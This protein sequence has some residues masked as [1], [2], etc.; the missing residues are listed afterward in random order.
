MYSP[1]FQDFQVNTMW[2]LWVCLGF[3]IVSEIVVLCL[4]VGRKPPLNMICLGFFTLGESYLV[5]LV[6]SLTAESDGKFVVLMAALMTLAITISV[7]VYAMVTKTDFTAR[8][9]IT[10]VLLCGL[11]FMGILS[12]FFYSQFMYVL[13]CTLGVVL[14]GIYLIIDTQLIMGGKRLALSIDDYA[15]AAMLLYVDIIQMFLY[16]LS[17]MRN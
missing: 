6:C 7:T 16:L 1:A 9:G 11:L 3:I 8:W 4:P 5:S 13:F 2:V 10:W 12:I 15:A 14:F 17:S